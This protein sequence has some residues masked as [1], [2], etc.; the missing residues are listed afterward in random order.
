MIGLVVR[1]F[2]E[3]MLLVP[4][5]IDLCIRAFGNDIRKVLVLG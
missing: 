4:L 3:E 2:A 5:R 1:D